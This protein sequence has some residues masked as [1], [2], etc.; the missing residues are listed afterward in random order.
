MLG[1]ARD[2]IVEARKNLKLSHVVL[3]FRGRLKGETGRSFHFVV[4]KS[5]WRGELPFMR[6]EKLLGITSLQT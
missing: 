4:V 2:Y 1:E 6:I 5:S 3:L